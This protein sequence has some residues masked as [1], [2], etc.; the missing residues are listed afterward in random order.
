MYY[1]AFF[2][3]AFSRSIGITVILV[4][5]LMMVTHGFKP[6]LPFDV[7]VFALAIAGDWSCCSSPTTSG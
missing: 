3:D 1:L 4:L 6:S 7:G 2:L 5:G